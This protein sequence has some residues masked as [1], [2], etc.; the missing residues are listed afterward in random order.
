M[1]PGSKVR[2]IYTATMTTGPLVCFDRLVKYDLQAPAGCKVV[3]LIDHGGPRYVGG[4]AFFVPRT[5]NRF[6]K[7]GKHIHLGDVD[8]MLWAF[9]PCTHRRRGLWH[10]QGSAPSARMCASSEP[11]PSAGV[12][13]SGNGTAK[14]PHV[15][16]S[17]ISTSPCWHKCSRAG[18]KVQAED[19]AGGKHAK[20]LWQG[21]AS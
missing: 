21:R 10:C 6:F 14:E 15:Y 20:D 2:F 7:R 11:S 8:R 12:P 17:T 19:A 5:T 13:S 9:H 1:F 3:G 4:E 16:I 18:N